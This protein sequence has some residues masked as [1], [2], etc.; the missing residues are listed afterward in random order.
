[1]KLAPARLTV[2][3]PERPTLKALPTSGPPKTIDDPLSRL[4]VP[5]P[6]AWNWSP[7]ML[8]PPVALPLGLSCS[9]APLLR[10]IT[11]TPLTPRPT[12]RPAPTP[13]SA[14]PPLSTMVALLR[15]TV[16]C[17]LV[18]PATALAVPAPMTMLVAET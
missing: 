9:C 5:V 17:A 12:V 1:M 2:P 14:R 3:V 4:S 6:P 7:P 8:M 10:F 16:P 13:T 11:P 15:L 18:G